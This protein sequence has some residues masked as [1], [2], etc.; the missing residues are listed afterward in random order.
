MATEHRKQNPTR[1]RAARV[2]AT[3][4]A[5]IRRIESDYKLPDGSVRLVLPSGRKAHMDGKIANLLNRWE[6]E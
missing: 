6:K 2:D 4:G 3:V 5:I 1:F